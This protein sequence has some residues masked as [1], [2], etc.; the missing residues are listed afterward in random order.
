MQKLKMIV[1]LSCLLMM[2]A[3]AGF[4]DASQ[5]DVPDISL[6]DLKQAIAGKQVTL[7]DCNGSK[8]FAQGHIPGAID[9]QASKADLARLLP[10]EKTALVVA[11]CG[12]PKCLAYQA[13]AE[14]AAKLGYTNV[15]H[16][17]GG[18]SGWKQAGENME[19]ATQPP[20]P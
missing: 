17:S 6:A 9:F 5:G 11:Y 2:C 3:A 15:K 8:S 1:P 20:T 12:G 14:A 19:P 16:F 10:P 13:G 7:I 18:L 4:S